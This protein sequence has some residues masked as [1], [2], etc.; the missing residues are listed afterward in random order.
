MVF[1]CFK[2]GLAHN[3]SR[4]ACQQLPKTC[5]RSG[6]R[7]YN[8][9]PQNMNDSPRSAEK[10]MMDVGIWKQTSALAM[11]K[12]TDTTTKSEQLSISNNQSGYYLLLEQ[13]RPR[14]FCIYSLTSIDAVWPIYCQHC[15]MTIMTNPGVWSLYASWFRCDNY[16]YQSPIRIQDCLLNFSANIFLICSR[17]PE[18]LFF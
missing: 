16:S 18:A 4:S 1:R 7:E 6:G 13:I 3:P 14:K 9:S 15:R 8:C 12:V 11:L 10:E 2:G 5:R 17:L